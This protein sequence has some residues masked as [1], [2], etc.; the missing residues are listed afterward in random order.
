MKLGVRR[1]GRTPRRAPRF[2]PG[3]ERCTRQAGLGAWA[4][5]WSPSHGRDL[6][7]AE[8]TPRERQD[9]VHH[10]YI[11]RLRPGMG[12]WLPWNAESREQIETNLFGVLWVTQA[13]LPFLRAQGSGHILQVSSISGTSAFPPSAFITRRSGALEGLSQSL[14]KEIAVFGIKVTLIEPGGYSTDWAGSSAKR[15]QSAARLRQGP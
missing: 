5:T 1:S 6:S 14:A 15:P 12:H 8:E 7:Y 3:P 4:R 10:R 13:A 9:L 2:T 11:P